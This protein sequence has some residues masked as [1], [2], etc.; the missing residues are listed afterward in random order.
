V[1]D[2]PHGSQRSHRAQRG[3]YRWDELPGLTVTVT[4]SEIKDHDGNVVEVIG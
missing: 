1:S 4:P 2:E 3:I